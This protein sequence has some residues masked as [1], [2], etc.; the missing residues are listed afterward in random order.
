MGPRSAVLG[1]VGVLAL[2]CGGFQSS[3]PPDSSPPAEAL[4]AWTD[5]A[6]DRSPRP[7]ILLED[8][9]PGLGFSGGNGKLA[10][11][12]GRFAAA[13]PLPSTTPAQAHVTW[14]DRSD[15][16]FTAISASDAYVA[17][18]ANARGKSP[19]CAT[20]PPLAITQTRL[21]A[22]TYETDRGQAQ[23][24]SWLFT[25]PGAWRE[26]AYPALAPSALWKGGWSDWSGESASISADGLSLTF[27]FTGAK[28]GN[29]PCEA[30][31][32]GLV[33]ESATAVAV[34][35][36]QLPNPNQPAGG[37]CTA[38][39]YPRH[40]TVSLNRP[41][42]GRVVVDRRAAVLAVCREGIT[43]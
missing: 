11:M 7:I 38:E 19:D 14:G 12:C 23:I 37:A 4:A 28:A 3:S 20:V 15:Q 35:P 18:A 10:F 5:F 39:G 17:M 27:G 16:T 42:E 9:T 2:S 33:M 40:V 21:A 32:R 36:Q 25:A 6:A 8:I 43:C 1:L 26:I 22:E 41:L 34:A 29:G 30:N 24:T 13:T 31:Y